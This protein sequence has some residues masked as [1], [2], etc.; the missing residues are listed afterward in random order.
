M[1]HMS[2][3]V[4]VLW[5]FAPQVGYPQ[6]SKLPVTNHQT[7]WSRFQ[8]FCK[9]GLMDYLEDFRMCMYVCGWWKGE[10][11]D[12]IAAWSWNSLRRNRTLSMVFADDDPI[13]G[14]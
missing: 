5:N 13:L 6:G 10:P 7:E 14:F 12:G 3:W 8:R 11:L 9:S 1:Q 4:P 2:F